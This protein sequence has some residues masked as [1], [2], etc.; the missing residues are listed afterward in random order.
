MMTK[1]LIDL[2]FF[3][4]LVLIFVIGYG[5]STASIMYPQK[6]ESFSKSSDVVSYTNYFSL[7]SD[8]RPGPHIERLQSVLNGNSTW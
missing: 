5:V 1:M 8:N 4:F 6:F 2:Q 3:I 7:Y